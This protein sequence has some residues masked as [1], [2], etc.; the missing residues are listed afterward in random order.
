MKKILSLALVL[1]MVLSCLTINAFAANSL[2]VNLDCSADTGVVDN[3]FEVV[4]TLKGATTLYSSNIDI[5]YD[6]TVVVPVKP[7]GATITTT[8][9]GAAAVTFKHDAEVE[10]DVDYNVDGEDHKIWTAAAAYNTIDV[11][12]DGLDWFHFEYGMDNWWLQ[13]YERKANTIDN[14]YTLTKIKFKR[15][16]E[17]DAKFAFLGFDAALSI[18][19]T[20]IDVGDG[21]LAVVPATLSVTAPTVQEPDN[22]IVGK[23]AKGT[24]SAGAISFTGKIR[25]DLIGNDYGVIANGKKFAGAKVGDTVANNTVVEMSGKAFDGTFQIDLTNIFDKLSVETLD[26]AGSF[27]VGNETQAYTTVTVNK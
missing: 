5:Q 2:E 12:T 23:D 1:A 26:V 11:L 21:S 18:I 20:K 27:Y 22:T 13:N 8:T 19:G 16:A 25:A 24:A 10:N 3:V 4:L 15:I 7:N 6:N 9:N 17:G 14:P